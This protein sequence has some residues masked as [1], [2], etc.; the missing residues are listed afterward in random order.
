MGGA[1][2]ALPVNEVMLPSGVRV[3]IRAASASK[4]T[5]RNQVEDNEA[6]HPRAHTSPGAGHEAN[7][8]ASPA[9]APVAEPR[10]IKE[11]M[12]TRALGRQDPAITVTLYCET[13]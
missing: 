5:T 2:S 3:G 11:K 10:T 6:P 12:M 9:L 1:S 4:L 7:T 8:R 13:F